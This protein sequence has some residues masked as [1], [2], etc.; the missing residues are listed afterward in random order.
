MGSL[1]T[2]TQDI[3]TI[4]VGFLPFGD[5]FA[6]FKVDA[7]ATITF[8]HLSAPLV[9]RI[10]IVTGACPTSGEATTVYRFI[11]PQTSPIASESACAVTPGAVTIVSGS[12]LSS[13]ITAVSGDDG[14]WRAYLP[15]GT[16]TLSHAGVESEPFTVVADDIVVAVVTDY[17]RQATGDVSVMRQT[18]VGTA[19]DVITVSGSEIAG[20]P[21][22]NPSLGQIAVSTDDPGVAPAMFDFSAEGLLSFSLRPG[23]YTLRDVTSGVSSSITV[24]AGQRAYVAITSTAPADGGVTPGGGDGSGDGGNAGGDPIGSGDGSGSVDGSDQ[25]GQASDAS[26]VAQ[27]ASGSAGSGAGS[28]NVSA[29]PDTGSGIGPRSG[30]DIARLAGMLLL[31]ATALGASAGWSRRDARRGR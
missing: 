27:S 11:E 8:V 17:T 23:D 6:S 31:L 3:A 19:A 22:C 12:G 20:E 26:D 7:D 28:V 15:F 10:Q 29:L 24:V 18:C 2:A 5:G 25:S 1:F 13:P 30:P 14:A 21:S 9:G 4:P 16:Y